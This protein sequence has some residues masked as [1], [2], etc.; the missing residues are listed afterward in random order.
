MTGSQISLL[1][2]KNISYSDAGDKCNENV[3]DSWGV[4]SSFN[5][6]ETHQGGDPKRKFFDN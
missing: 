2:G 1:K 6:P 5:F 4:T 3:T